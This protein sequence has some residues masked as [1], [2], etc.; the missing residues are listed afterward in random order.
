MD[1][2]TLAVGQ[3][4]TTKIWK[5]TSISW[6]ELLERLQ[7]TTR[8]PETQGEYSNSTKSRQDDIKDVGGFVGGKLREGKRRAG[9][10]DKRYLLTLDADYASEDFVDALHLFFDFT[11]CVYSTHKHTPD[12]PRYRLLM[13]LSRPCNPDEYEAIA[14]KVAEDIGIDMFDDTTYQPHRLMY[15]PS[16]S[17]DGEYVFE[18]KDGAPLDV[19]KVLSQ[20]DDWRD[21][22]SWPSSS[23]TVDARKRLVKKQ[24]D[25]TTKKG[26]VGAFCRVYS[27]DDAIA[28]FLPDVYIACDKDG[29]YTYANGS[30]AAGLVI[31]DDG[32]FAYSN[33]ATDPCGGMLCNAFDLVRL[34]KFGL[35]DDEAAEGTP[36]VKLPSYL[37]M[38]DFVSSDA[39]VKKLL[40][41]ERM[42]SV[43]DDFAG[44]SDVES[45]EKENDDWV[46]GLA[47]DGK[48]RYVSTIDNVKT[49]IE[50][51]I[52]LKGKVRL[53]EF[54][55]RYCVFDA[56]PWDADTQLRD[57]SDPDDAGLRHYLEKAYGIKGK[58]II[59]D[60]WVLAAGGHRYHPIKDYLNMLSWDGV[61][62]VDTL[63]T[64]YM[65]ADDNPYVRTVTRKSL[66]AA[67]ARVFEPGVKYDTMLTLVGPQGC[68]KSQ[69]IK[70]L[71]GEW[72]SD[73][74]DSMRGKDAYEQ[75]QGFWIIEVGELAAMKKME[76][77][78][79]KMFITKT[80]DS[81]RAAYGHHVETHKRQCVFFG[82]TNTHDFL[83]DVTGN[84]RFWP[85]DV[86]P[87]KVKRDLWAELGPEN[88]GQ[89]WAEALALY[90]NGES[91]DI[92]DEAIKK[93]AERAQEGHLER[94]PLEGLINDYLDKLLPED[95][96]KYDLSARRA[97]Y[98]GND[99]G[100]GVIGTVKRQKVCA[101]EIWCELLGGDK[102]ELTNSKNKEIRD[103]IQCNNGWK[104]MKSTGRF[105]FLYGIQRGFIR[106]T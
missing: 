100:T 46:E 57:W 31:Y 81:Y 60:A 7:T 102:K 35:Q 49:I 61:E 101:L 38:L 88:I 44:L 76:V 13:P 11:W 74:L 21:V 66:V 32:K 62:R 70:R 19:D 39:A 65:G 94:N 84:R 89:I 36:V 40:H 78:A 37:A 82:T 54:T 59:T 103:A 99:F 104:S 25:P 63:F 23:R 87:K 34:H 67:V 28:K 20:Y 18:H 1:K 90:K 3:S 105:G 47:V 33:H 24:E 86:D 75:I 30:T 45:P 97:Y 69:I 53:N 96:D 17:I 73:T 22:T 15:W 83:K 10:I 41:Q 55:K 106:I 72:F 8:T 85:V 4:R 58:S 27:V 52:N 29:R 64:D 42:L 98:Q 43:K 93:M 48:G 80:E 68:G 77:E 16:T 51:D 79:T 6:A 26:L 14:R 9:Y 56:L 91:L 2:L 12:K 50:H 5:N 71:G 92:K 95:W